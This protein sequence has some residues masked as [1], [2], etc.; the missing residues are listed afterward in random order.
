MTTNSVLYKNRERKNNT[1]TSLTQKISVVIPAYNEEKTLGKTIMSV[2]DAGIVSKDI[3]I[4]DDGSTDRTEEIATIYGVHLIQNKGNLGKADSLRD[5]IHHRELANEYEFIALLDADT[6]VDPGYFSRMLSQAE[7]NQDVVLFIG[8]VKSQ[9]HNW[10]TG[11]RAMDYAYMHDIYKSAQSKYSMITVGPGCASIYRTRALKRIQIS[12]D[13][14]AEDMDWTIQ[15]YRKNLGRI[16]Y[17]PEALVYTQDPETLWDYIRQIRRWYSGSFQ[18]IRKHRIMS[19]LTR[20]DL[21]LGFL[22]LEGL[23]YSLLFAL[24]P[25]LFPYMF[26]F[27]WSWVKKI[28]AIDFMMLSGFAFY[29]SVRNR[30]PDI[31]LR[32]PLFYITRYINA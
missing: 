32:F 9:K 8:Q 22:Y 13:T 6:M 27:H 3:Y 11:A 5:L 17:V 7:R 1:L 4:I 15:V 23:V 10:I 21:E 14:L 2:L 19:R 25:I 24:L 26:F 16:L 20:I 12:N 31:F 28:A 18:V 30:R 29:A